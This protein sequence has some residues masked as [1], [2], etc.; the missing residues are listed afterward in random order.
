MAGRI[1]PGFVSAEIGA[2]RGF[3]LFGL[4]VQGGELLRPR[5]VIVLAAL[6]SL[7]V[8][9]RA[10]ADD[11]DDSVASLLA[12]RCLACHSSAEK[13]GGLDLS[14]AKSALAG[15][16]S[17]E[18]IAPGKPDDSL[19]WERVSKREM[20][21]KKPLPDDEQQVLKRWIAGGAK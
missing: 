10:R 4:N 6:I 16:D 18:A 20:P 14:S 12:R 13:K 5:A 9:A 19:L 15:G 1:F 2:L 11:F 7:V 21:P 3:P 8:A 17:G